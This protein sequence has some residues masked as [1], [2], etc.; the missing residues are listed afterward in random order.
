M[1]YNYSTTESFLKYNLRPNIFISLFVLHR[2]S[3][4]KPEA[5]S[6]AVQRSE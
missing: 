4:M 5:P 2:L 1:F 6:A 3:K